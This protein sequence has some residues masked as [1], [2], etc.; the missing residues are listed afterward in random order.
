MTEGIDEI[1]TVGELTDIAA[2]RQA[3]SFGDSDYNEGFFRQKL[4]DP[5][6]E[7]VD[8][9]RKLRNVDQ[10][11]PVAVLAFGESRGTY[12]PSGISPRL[13]PP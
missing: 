12:E 3:D 5:G 1:N 8:I 9:K 10:V 13:R 7:V 6:Q 11:R 2:V 4:P